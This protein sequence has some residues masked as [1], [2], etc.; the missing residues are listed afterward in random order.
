MGVFRRST[1]RGWVFGVLLSALCFACAADFDT[2][3]ATPPR[4]TLGHELFGLVCDRVGAQ[5]LREDVTGASFH[6]VCHPS[7]G[8]T[9]ADKVDTSQLVLLDPNATDEA[10]HVVSLPTQQAN[11]AHRI[12]RIEALARRREDFAAA[13]DHAVPSTETIGVKD[14]GATDPRASC[15]APSGKT[16]EASLQK[17]LGATLGRIVD[18]YDDRTIPMLTEALADVME[19]VRASP[20]TQAALARFDARQGYRPAGVATGM[21]RPALSYPHLV[22]LANALLGIVSS[23]GKASEDLQ[24]L[25]ATLHEEL[26]ASTI[27]P[28]A[29]PLAALPD[30]T[31][32]SRL[33]LS[34]PRGS[35]ELAR[36]LLLTE[37]SAFTSGAPRYVVVRDPRGVADV[38]RPAGQLPSLFVDGDKDGLADLDALGQFVTTNGAPAPSPFF[39]ADGT[40]G[41]TRDAFGR[42][43]LYNYVD[44]SRTLLGSLLQSLAPLLDPDPSHGREA[45]MGLVGGLPIVLGSRDAGA[46]STRTYSTGATLP[47]RAFHSDD[48]PLVDLAYAVGQILAPDTTDDTLAFVHALADQHPQELARLVGIG[49]QIK[50]IADKHPEAKIPATSTLWDELLDTFAKI[51][52]T[53]G[54]LEDLFL[55]FGKDETLAVRNAFHAYVAYKDELTYDKQNLNG[56]AFDLT[57]QSVS[58]MKTPVD[59]T[60]PDTGTNRSDLQRFMQLLHDANGLGACTKDGAVAHVKWKGLALD[61]PTDFTAQAACVLLTG[62]L[63][64]A[65]LP[66]CGILRIENVAALLLDVALGRAKFDIR[67]PCLAQLVASPLT[68]VVG[69]ADAFLETVSGIKGFSTHPTVNG[70]SRLVYYDTPHDGLPGDASNPQTMAFLRDI[71]DPVPSMVCPLTPYTDPSDGKVIPLRTCG[72][73]ADTLRGRDPNALFP[74]EQLDFIKDVGPLAAAFADH[75]APLLFVELFDTLHLHWGSTRQSADECTKTGTRATNPRWCAQDGAVTYE[76]L[77]ADVLETDLFQTLHDIVPVLKSITVPHC[78]AEDATTHACTKATPKD[79]VAVLADAIRALVD[80]GKNV[81]LRDRRG[82]QL[83]TRNDGTTNPQVTPI[84]LLVDAL[85]AFDAAFA[86]R[87][88]TEDRLGPWRAARS[89]LT[90]TFF[91]VKG[92]GTQAMFSNG[93]VPKAIPL[94]TAAIREQV[95]ARCPS[96][97]AG[98]GCPWARETMPKNFADVV[99][100]PSL[101][102]TVDLLEAARSDPAARAELERF[103]QFLLTSPEGQADAATAGASVD[104]LQW[105][106]DDANLVPLLHGV[107]AAFARAQATDGRVTKRSLADASIEVLARVLAESRDPDGTEV[108]AREKD[109]SHALAAVLGHLMTPSGPDAPAP[110]EVLIDV[111][112]DVNRAHPEE[113]TKLA[114]ADYASIAFEV[115]DFCVNPARGL[116]Q[117]YEVIREATLP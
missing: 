74:L 87:A 5:A 61:Y 49:L 12:A 71:I 33:V 45:I 107:A 82:S 19:G 54:I 43:P 81:G 77:L 99:G 66:L 95:A 26:R 10:G 51:A 110:I 109:P 59:R 58:P 90:D 97:R 79:G 25:M 55:A 101:A 53:P 72:S 64:P 7:A 111:V 6:A 42:L 115:K 108:C 91:G 8:G 2:A 84:Y 96:A 47:Y 31:D 62:T 63:P 22:P 30:P 20:D 76:P 104:L 37:D 68:G 67:D 100:G 23:R 18:L 41:A 32:P 48:A 46:T 98:G 56:D 69:G 3:R 40:D 88:G 27:D 94:L 89:Q 114:A 38:A 16:G 86:A 75:G 35:L 4:G 9:W 93:W 17:E 50:A 14:L 21:A 106:A 113:R 112:A 13:I 78:V 85:H 116:E 80:P 60:L 102:S 92:T 103:A 73:F 57:T 117:V 29:P 34:R 44:T 65:K 11:R 105:L 24:Q 39:A 70:V 83:G 1:G 28:P 52:Q 15:A 36:T